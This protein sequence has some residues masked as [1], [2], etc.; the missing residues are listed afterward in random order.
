MNV[1]HVSGETVQGIT[2]IEFIKRTTMK[3]ATTLGIG[4]LL[5]AASTPGM[6]LAQEAAAVNRLA[7]TANVVEYGAKGDGRT[8]DREAFQKAIDEADVI[9]VPRPAAFYRIVGSLKAGG[10]DGRGQKRFVG[11]TITRDMIDRGVILRGDG[12]GPLFITGTYPNGIGKQNR[13]ISFENISASNE[14]FPVV[15]FHSAVNFL[16]DRCYLASYKNTDATLSARYSYRGTIKDSTVICSGG[17]FAITAYDNC[18]GTR[19][20]DCTLAGGSAGGV[21]HLEQS[22]GCSF[23]GNVIEVSKYGLA[24][25]TFVRPD[26]PTEPQVVGAG[27]VNGFDCS[28]N[29]F[30]TVENPLLLG[31][32]GTVFAASIEAN[33]FGTSATALKEY[34][35]SDEPVI[36][37]GRLHG[38]AIRANSF[39][40]PKDS[41]QPIISATATPAATHPFMQANTIESNVSQNGNGPFFSAEKTITAGINSRNQ[42]QQDRGLVAP[43]S[44]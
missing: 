2:L 41:K 20:R 7:A 28:G 42:I 37:I 35:F 32:K 27:N 36:R 4:L 9:I 34:G 8:D 1:P 19:I 13:G 17:G 21:L 11:D 24:V 25:A 23:T 5:A 33:Y 30:E 10:S 15:Q 31:T 6:S 43:G 44:K 40:Q 16:I 29:Y 22:Q 38:S 18:N 14:K 26:R 3:N 12:S 39:Y